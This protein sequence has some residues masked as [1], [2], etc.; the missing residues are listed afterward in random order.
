MGAHFT[1]Y[2]KTFVQALLT[3]IAE[4]PQLY[5][6]DTPGRQALPLKITLVEARASPRPRPTTPPRRRGV[7]GARSS[8]EGHSGPMRRSVDSIS[9]ISGTVTSSD[10]DLRRLQPRVTPR[11]GPGSALPKSRSGSTST[12][13]SSSSGSTV[14]PVSP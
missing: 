5:R 9:T 7:S 13:A 2:R 14:P 10:H 8:G 6:Y 3:F 12:S 4:P 1:G 11:P